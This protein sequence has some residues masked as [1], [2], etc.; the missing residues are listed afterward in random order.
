[1]SHN[2]YQPRFRFSV[3]LTT[4]VVNPLK[5]SNL[6]FGVPH[7]GIFVPKNE[8]HILCSAHQELSIAVEKIYDLSL[9]K[10]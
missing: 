3:Y 9:F 8:Y 7:E 4:E 2:L 1:M 6:G 5:L 10:S